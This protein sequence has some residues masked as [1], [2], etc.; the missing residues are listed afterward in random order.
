MYVLH[1]H[2]LVLRGVHA[3]R[4]ESSEKGISRTREFD[5][6]AMMMVAGGCGRVYGLGAGDDGK[7]LT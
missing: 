5:E 2:V 1:M 6:S 4:I 3:Y 7:F